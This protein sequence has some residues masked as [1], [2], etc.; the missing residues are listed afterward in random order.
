ML[1]FHLM[2]IVEKM[3]KSSYDFFHQKKLRLKT[4]EEQ[5]LNKPTLNVRQQII[6]D[7]NGKEESNYVRIDPHFDR[8][9]E[10]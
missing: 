2:R 9:Y 8:A 5:R 10:Q 3:L 4:P 6:D 1:Q 7:L